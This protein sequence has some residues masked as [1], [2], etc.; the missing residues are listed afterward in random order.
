MHSI[1][2]CKHAR[3]ELRNHLAA[4]GA[5]PDVHRNLNMRAS[6]PQAGS[7]TGQRLRKGPAAQKVSTPRT[8]AKVG[9]EMR[10]LV[11]GVAGFTGRRI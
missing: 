1:D 6:C 11:T 2:R 3:T 8:P 10:V 9:F 7:A 5:Y 4:V